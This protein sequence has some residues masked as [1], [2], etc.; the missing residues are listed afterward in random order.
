MRWIEEVYKQENN[1]HSLVKH[2]FKFQVQISVPERRVLCRGLVL[3]ADV[4][5]HGEC[6]AAHP[7]VAR[8]VEAGR[9]HEDALDEVVGLRKVAHFLAH[10][11]HLQ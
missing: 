1:K 9:G 6:G 7:A 8:V 3:A 2:V 10:G 4:V 11:T 5:L